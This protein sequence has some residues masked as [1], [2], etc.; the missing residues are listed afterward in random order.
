MGNTNEMMVEFDA[1][2]E[3]EGFARVVVAAFVSRLNPTLEELGDLKV[4]V[5]EAVTNAIIHG[6]DPKVKQATTTDREA[7]ENTAAVTDREAGEI[8]A[9]TTEQEAGENTA[10]ATDR[11][12]VQ[13]RVHIADHTVTVQVKDHGRGIPDITQ[14][15]EPLFTTKPEEERSG[16]G[17]SFMEAFTD[18]LLVES[19]PGQ[20]TCVTMVKTMGVQDGQD[21]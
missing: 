20:G 12:T 8:P 14:A 10:A 4:A 2:G 13:I 1:V 16:M 7:G 18:R 21:N 5:S 11:D 17:F 15:M 19:E 6:Y 3:N 9:A